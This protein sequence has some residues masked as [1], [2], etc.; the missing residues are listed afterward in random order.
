MG[1]ISGISTPFY[2]VYGYVSQT[3]KILAFEYII[4]SQETIII[5]H[6]LGTQAT[7]GTVTYLFVD[8][9]AVTV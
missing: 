1:S 5:G 7:V 8:Y 2:Q 9:I 6:M 4:I 3:D